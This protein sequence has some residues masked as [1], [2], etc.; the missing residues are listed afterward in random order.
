[1]Q[2]YQLLYS[3][4]WQQILL[5]LCHGGRGRRKLGESLDVL[6]SDVGLGADVQYLGV[7]DGASQLRVRAP[8]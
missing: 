7:C 8:A 4:L 5:Q 1:M 2:R 3:L 6:E